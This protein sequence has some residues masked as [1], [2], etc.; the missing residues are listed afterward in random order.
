[1]PED[2]LKLEMGLL[3]SKAV[4]TWLVKLTSMR[5]FELGSVSP[6]TAESSRDSGGMGI[7][8]LLNMATVCDES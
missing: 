7:G 6:S 2:I 8:L 1:M 3:F 4:R 5:L